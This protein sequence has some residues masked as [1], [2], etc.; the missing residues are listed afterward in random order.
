MSEEKSSSMGGGSGGMS[1]I[2]AT[3]VP[4]LAPP[5]VSDKLPLSPS[6][7][8][9]CSKNQSHN[10]GGRCYEE[11][12]MEVEE[13]EAKE[14][15]NVATTAA[16]SFTTNMYRNAIDI[17]AQ[18]LPLGENQGKTLQLVG[19]IFQKLGFE[20]VNVYYNICF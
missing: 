9:S 14:N 16:N 15:R 5:A 17:F 7:Q 12:M 6:A 1:A 10:D 13:E 3:P 20:C 18:T 11:Q 8:L 4:Q 19:K 2:T